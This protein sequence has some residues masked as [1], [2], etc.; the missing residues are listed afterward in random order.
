MRPTH[1]ERIQLRDRQRRVWH[2]SEVARLKV[3]AA[4]VDGP[5]LCLVIWFER[6]GDER[7]ARW[8]GG[9]EWR[10]QRS[11]HRLFAKAGAG[12]AE[13]N[14]PPHHIR[15]RSTVDDIPAGAPPPNAATSP[16]PALATQM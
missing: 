2:V 16:A 3:V 10:R 1:L 13:T 5:S 6:E 7:F 12:T 9:E 11:L 4:P 15:P 8:I 14:R